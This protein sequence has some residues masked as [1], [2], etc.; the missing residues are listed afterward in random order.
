MA[1][2]KVKLKD[3]LGRV[4]RL[5]DG[6]AGATLGVNLY[7]ANGKLLTAADII[8]PPPQTG[9]SS[10]VW[11]LIREVP[12]NLKAI[13]ALDGVGHAVR[14]SSGEWALRTIQSGE[15]IEV[16]D[17]DGDAGD[18]TIALSDL[19][20]SGSGTLLAITRDEK[21]RVSGTRDATTTD[22]PEGTNLYYTDG[23]VDARINLQKGQP[24]GLTPLGSD[25][26]IPVEYLP[27]YP[28]V[29]VTSVNGQTGDVV[30][31]AADV[32]AAT[33]AQGDLA[34]SAVQPGDL[35]TVA[36]SGAYSDLIGLPTL[37]TAAAADA[38][39]FATAV[40]GLLADTALQ[41]G[42][43]HNTA[44]SGLQG[45]AAGEYYHLSSAERS[46][47][48]PASGTSA[49]FLRG[50]GTWSNALEGTLSAV[51]MIN[52][53]SGTPAYY[54]ATSTGGIE[55][56]LSSN[57]ALAGGVGFF[58][59]LT[60][61]DLAVVANGGV[62]AYVAKN[63]ANLRPAIDNDMA[64]GS[65]SARFSVVYAA[66]GS[67]N[68]SDAREKTEVR[69]LS[70]DEL[71]AA[72]AL[73]REIGAYK[74]L[75]S[76]RAKGDAARLHIG[77]TVQRAIEIMASY[78]LDPFAYGFICYD[79]WAARPEVCS[80]WLREVEGGGVAA[81]SVTS[82]GTAAGDLYSFRPDG[83]H[84][85]IARGILER[86]DRLQERLEALEDRMT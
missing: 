83:L 79:R 68:T 37:G 14:R 30:L 43:A 65:G 1:E 84:A 21:G 80:E 11:K 81:S 56:V 54:Q 38:A 41:P 23:R 32:G 47:V 34:E 69:P 12:A 20:D 59:T 53:S 29:P 13:A 51:G 3:Q 57:D 8:N 16:E 2:K 7:G 17:G 55:S 52:I 46:R 63:G 22:L 86:Q 18:P 40:Q 27:P 50:D 5:D 71:A 48:P 72:V 60:N 85:F 45:G 39:D 36:T 66:A 82:P 42:A 61:H 19:P 31:T 35:A 24:N 70:V 75:E 73:G 74:W 25:S 76:I 44:L 6:R 28:D 49:K 4:V 33:E 10:T 64:L 67:I 62:W 9:T 77:M 78:G 15:G 26:L 58:G